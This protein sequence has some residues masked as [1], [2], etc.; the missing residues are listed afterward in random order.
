MMQ[1]L[2]VASDPIGRRP[3]PIRKGSR[4]ARALS[5]DGSG[6]HLRSVRG[7]DL[8]GLVRATVHPPP[9]RAGFVVRPRL[10]R[11]ML[12]AREAT[13]VL[14]T[15][16]PGYGKTSLLSE[17]AG[18]DERPFVWIGLCQQDNDAAHL[19]G[20]LA[21]ALDRIEPL[22]GGV[23]DALGCLGDA[24]TAQ[25]LSAAVDHI[26]TVVSSMGRTRE[27]AVLV[28]DD[29]HLLRSEEALGVVATVVAAMP[30]CS[31]VALA[32]R[33]EPPLA[34]GRLRAAHALMELGV[35]DLAMTAYEAH[36]LIAASGA[37]LERAALEQLVGRTEGWPAGIYLASRSHDAEE[38]LAASAGELAGDD[39][40]IAAY[41]TEEILAPLG[42]ELRVFLWRTSI[43]DQL[44]PDLCDAVLGRSDSGRLLNALAA[45]NL[46]VL[47]LDPARR[48]FRCHA[49]LRDALRAELRLH[50]PGAIVELNRRASQWFADCNDVDR[51][52]QHA[53]A[54]GDA[55]RVGELLWTHAAEYLMPGVEP[56][57]HRFLGGFSEERIASCPYLALAAAHGHLSAGDLVAAERWARAASEALTRDPRHERPASLEAGIALI[58]A[59]L[60]RG[61]IPQMGQ[62]AERAYAL[63]GEASP[64]RA[65]CCLLSGVA[66][67][68]AGEPSRAREQLDE[69]VHSSAGTLPLVAA[70]C[71][72]QLALID[73]EDGDWEHA[74]GQAK[75]AAGRL[76]ADGLGQHPLATL[77]FGV[78]AWIAAQQ[79][80]A[81]E[82]KHDLSA[83]N[84]LLDMLGGYMP[85][86]DVEARAVMARA[87][88][89]LAEVPAA[90]A[91][92]SQASRAARRLPETPVFRAWL[93]DA[94]AAIDERSAAALGGPGALTI[95]ELRILRF[96]PTHLSFR[97]IGERLHV[98][99]NTVKSQAHAVYGKL[100]ATSRSQAVARASALGLI[101]VT[102]V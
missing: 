7:S 28:L 37:S 8:A 76:A 84:Q 25:G 52:A 39:H 95:A 98:S 13:T 90:R 82:A 36:Q 70:L 62:D 22:D 9:F 21:F 50:D 99:T 81:D 41:L 12:L 1:A 80:H 44:S 85:W 71:L 51:A 5:L 91:L 56:R 89:Q 27:P 97:E 59:A 100:G 48:W 67:H 60:A 15:A 35:R 16:P 18:R 40:A 65:L 64:W 58:D 20:A 3:D 69:G 77:V 55:H 6:E 45:G 26:A 88:I 53:V 24:P 63:V 83:A 11:R 96:L 92:L 14:I 30:A 102:V 86:Y 32:S 74:L 72:A 87:S 46:M 93:D 29:L 38:D 101:E 47:P 54:A 68:L 61:G 75:L 78:C 43:L 34:L 19:L 33:T 10:V 17:W 31:K 4:G 57:V 2:D 23:L 79:R 94:W 66:H 49:L 42:S 73:A